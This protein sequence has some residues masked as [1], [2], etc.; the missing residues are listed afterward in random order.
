MISKALEDNKLTNR[1]VRLE[2]DILRIDNPL[3]TNL[4]S[5]IQ[6]MKNVCHNDCPTLMVQYALRDKVMKMVISHIKNK[7]EIKYDLVALVRSDFT[8]VSN[9]GEFINSLSNKT[10]SQPLVWL[11]KFDH[12]TGK[13]DRFMVCST[14]FPISHDLFRNHL[15][16]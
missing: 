11:H 3:V 15:A 13:N 7:A 1:V 14:L 9:I 16:K 10:L 5:I 8:F 12:W 4:T 6:E 2:Y